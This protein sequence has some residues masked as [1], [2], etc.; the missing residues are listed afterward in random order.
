MINVG[1]CPRCEKS[2]SNLTLKVEA[3]EGTV[4][5]G[6]GRFNCIQ[7]LCSGCNSVL[8]IQIDPLA[9][10]TDTVNEVVKRLGR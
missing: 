1:K 6:G 4:A 2:V 7:F 8:G 5:F 10:K 3:L 9:L